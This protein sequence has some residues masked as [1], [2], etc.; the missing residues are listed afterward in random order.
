MLGKNQLRSLCRG[1]AVIALSSGEAEYYG[2][3]TGISEAI[4]EQSIALDWGIKLPIVIH[5]DATAGAAIGSRRGLGKVKHISTVFLWAQ[6]R[7]TTGQVKIR[8]T[9][10]S[11]NL[12]DILTKAIDAST[13]RNAMKQMNFTFPEGRS[14]KAYKTD[15]LG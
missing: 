3:V 5:M 6:E 2:L 4:G 13:L 8:W 15:G 12:A 1:Q 11:V 9:H 7:V 14:D 10:T